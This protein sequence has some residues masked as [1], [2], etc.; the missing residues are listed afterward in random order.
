MRQGPRAHA[1]L[2]AGRQAGLAAVEAGHA[3]LAE[4][5]APAAVGQDHRLGDDQVE[6]RAALAGADLHL[7]VAGRLALVADQAE[8]VVGPVEVLGLAA[9][10]LALGL[11]LLRQAEQEGQ[12]RAQRRQHR[13]RF[14]GAGRASSSQASVITRVELVVAQ[15]GDDRHPLE[16]GLGAL[17]RQRR[18]VEVGVERDG[19]AVAPFLQRVGLDH[20]VGQHRDL[21]ARHVDRRHARARHLVDGAA[22]HQRQARA[23]RC[24]CRPPRCRCP[25]PGPRARRRSRWSANRRS[26]RPAP[27]PAAAR[28]RSPA[29]A[30]AG[31]RCPWGSSRTG[32]GASGTGRPSRSR[33]PASAAR[34]AGVCVA[35]AA[36]TTALYS[37]AFL[38]GLNRILNSCSRTG[39]GHS[40]AASCAG[41]FGDLRLH[42]LLLLDR[43]QCLLDDL[44]R[45]LLEAALAG[46]AEVVRR[47]EQRQQRRGLLRQRRTGLEI[48]GGQRRRSRIR[49]RARIPRRGR[50]RPWRRAPALGDQLGRRRLLE[51]QQRCWRP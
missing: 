8:G 37:G 16:P 18:L 5:A 32:S 45:R 28:R 43:G 44:G 26:R 46:A 6:R 38:S 12:R 41:P 42:Q 10:H 24:G 1:H 3:E 36:S 23:P 25:A 19:R 21:V 7:F 33:R 22:R 27:P 48:L 11:Q 2:D 35:R 34:A 9:H 20:V 51:A 17:Q 39:A 14:R 47:V 4:P 30:A 15:V 40:P 31:S 50:G 13:G 29:P 49:P